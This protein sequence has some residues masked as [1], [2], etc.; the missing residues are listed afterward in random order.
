MIRL[1]IRPIQLKEEPKN[2]V[3]FPDRL[4]LNPDAMWSNPRDY[5]L[6]AEVIS[7]STL[8][9]SEK[10]QFNPLSN[11]TKIID[12]LKDGESLKLSNVKF[13][14]IGTFIPAESVVTIS[15]NQ[16]ESFISAG[17]RTRID[18]GNIRV[19][20]FPNLEIVDAIP[21]QT[22]PVQ[23]DLITSPYQEVDLFENEVIQLNQIA[24]DLNELDNVYS[25][26]T[27]VFNIPASDR[28]IDITQHYFNVN[29]M[30]TR[31]KFMEA[32]ITLNG[33]TYKKGKIQINSVQYSN[34]VPS[35]ININFYTSVNSLIDSIG[36]DTLQDLEYQV[37]PFI[38][39]N[40][41]V[42]RNIT[43]QVIHP[44]F[45]IPLMSN[46]RAWNYKGGG[47]GDL[48][49][50][51]GAIRPTELRPAIP[52]SVI[53]DAIL[54]KYKLRVSCPL[55]GETNYSN[56]YA[57]LNNNSEDKE[58]T[59]N[60]N[61][62][63]GFSYTGASGQYNA[64]P[65]QNKMRITYSQLLP[66]SKG[67]IGMTLKNVINN[68]T[69]GFWSED[70]KIILSVTDAAGSEYEFSYDALSPSGNDLN[71]TINL[72]PY[73]F[74]N[75][76]LFGFKI[77]SKV[78]LSIE[79]FHIG[80]MSNLG[81]FGTHRIAN[82]YNNPI[83]VTQQSFN[84][85]ASLPNMKVVD[86]LSSFF[87]M[88]NITI[89]EEESDNY[90]MKW[91][92]PKDM[93]EEDLN[94]TDFVDH[95][96]IMIQSQTLY[97]SITFTHAENELF[98]NKNYKVATGKE[99]GSEMYV[100]QG[101]DNSETFEVETDYQVMNYFVLSGTTLVT[102][103][104]W[105]NNSEQYFG[106]DQLIIMYYNGRKIIKDPNFFD[107][108]VYFKYQ[109]ANNYFVQL[110]TYDEFTNIDTQ[111]GTSMTFDRDVHP[112]TLTEAKNTLYSEGYEELI[113]NTYGNNSRI[114]TV[115]CWLPSDIIK[116]L[117]VTKKIIIDDK[118]F[119]ISE[120]K[121]DLTTGQSELKL[122][123]LEY[124]V[125]IDDY[126]VNPPTTADTNGST[127]TSLSVV[128]QGSSVPEPHYI[129][130][131]TLEYRK[132]INATTYDENYLTID[133]PT[134]NNFVSHMYQLGNLTPNTTYQMRIRAYDETGKFSTW[135][136]FMKKTPAKL[137]IPLPD[138]GL[139]PIKGGI[140]LDV[141]LLYPI[142]SNINVTFENNLSKIKK[143]VVGSVSEFQTFSTEIELPEGSYTIYSTVTSDLGEVRNDINMDYELVYPDTQD[144]F[145]YVS[146][147][148]YNDFPTRSCL[149]AGDD[150]F[151]TKLYFR[152]AILA[153]GSTLYTDPNYNNVFQQNNNLSLTYKNVGDNVKYNLRSERGVVIDM[154]TCDRIAD[155]HEII[156]DDSED[157]S[158]GQEA[159]S[160]GLIRK[161]LYF[162]QT[163]EFIG[164]PLYK[165]IDYTN[166]LS[167]VGTFAAMA[168]NNERYFININ[169]LDNVTQYQ[170]CS[171]IPVSNMIS[172]D[173][174]S[175]DDLA[176][177]SC[178]ISMNRTIAAFN[179]QI[180]FS[181]SFGEGT[182][183]FLN[184]AL[185]IPYLPESVKS[186]SF[187]YE[188]VAGATIFNMRIKNGY[189]ENFYPCNLLNG[190]MDSVININQAV[191]SSTQAC[192]LD[193]LDKTLVFTQDANDW[194]ER[195]LYLN[196]EL[197]QT[198]PTSGFMLSNV[199]GVR[200]S[201][202]V[203][204]S[205]Y[206]TSVTNCGAN[207]ISG[208]RFE[209]NTSPQ[210]GTTTTTNGGEIYFDSLTVERKA[211]ISPTNNMLF[212]GNGNY[213]RV[214]M[215]MK[216]YWIRIDSSGT[217]REIVQC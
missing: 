45:K 77:I 150:S 192:S 61:V 140:K 21:I 148:S 56:M 217:I 84:V 70:I 22:V 190:K 203:N 128:F 112:M 5:V 89:I 208:R 193:M 182:S 184:E 87:K 16:L 216:T 46:T 94:I 14:N 80:Y 120:I 53:M 158:D 57:Y 137:L 54:K 179:T 165:D 118:R 130:G 136:E 200:K 173:P 181:G 110:A 74:G 183:L 50:N 43:G 212:T 125:G 13:T 134:S 185:T 115:N 19:P 106:T 116:K 129:A 44:Q 156:V 141:S 67:M 64:T 2:A 147:I 78:P 157:Y 123:Y 32:V 172:I 71:L 149:L 26:F 197:T 138:L 33:E 96:D 27:Q 52:Y 169:A 102:S 101:S 103:Y 34:G 152:D 204:N 24:K 154:Y 100:D 99:Y 59:L 160:V 88:F 143:S 41:N 108:N 194:Y 63:N 111:S 6:D 189:V 153:L 139:S 60:M 75:N 207:R 15:K 37:S 170:T 35:S 121:T 1:Y 191:S 47:I 4:I 174:N 202:N 144:R 187:V 206:V 79:N 92:R 10:V 146:E 93:I 58:F 90:V 180:Y 69:G 107:T 196:P 171:T 164:Q 109:L 9:R 73:Q 49:E 86:F 213:Y 39:N 119:M 105:E 51:V 68:N 62:V 161:N 76:I 91:L 133:L 122:N 126:A 178:G 42:Y 159:C 142:K 127:P 114:F 104:A 188:A 151:N 11:V 155:A 145:I 209:N 31:S 175:E 17:G 82:S 117:D 98:R 186:V 201:F 29:Y 124:K 30:K 25:P 48:F 83:S 18:I 40:E 97:K 177:L 81:I 168:V 215:G 7:G 131:H 12:K 85:N 166:K 199:S 198:I 214:V 210:C 135:V 162:S 28:N 176:T 23:S 38:W 95:A 72:E 113:R 163:S 8:I 36:E 132:W 205:A 55:F 195:R 3:T 66:S 20:E 167:K 65:Y 211:Y